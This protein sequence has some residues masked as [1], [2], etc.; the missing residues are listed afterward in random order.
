MCIF[1]TKI[2]L[3]KIYLLNDVV[4]LCEYYYKNIFNGCNFETC[5]YNERETNFSQKNF[6]EIINCLLWFLTK[7]LI[8]K[9]M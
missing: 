5:K 7:I 9:R 2:M 8:M 6:L 4:L 1:L 3:R